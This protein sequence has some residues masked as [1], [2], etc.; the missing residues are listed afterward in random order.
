MQD[1]KNWAPKPRVFSDEEELFI[2]DYMRVCQADRDR[3]RNHVPTPAEQELNDNV[4]ERKLLWPLDVRLP[5]IRTAIERLAALTP[6][7]PEQYGDEEE[8]EEE[9]E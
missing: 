8:E 4:E 6:I 9:D 3:D 1:I 2:T 7:K 5:L